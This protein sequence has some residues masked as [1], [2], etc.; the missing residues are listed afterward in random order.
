MVSK[1]NVLEIVK[2]KSPSSMV[3]SLTKSSY[4][5]SSNTLK[6]VAYNLLRNKQL[7]G[8]IQKITQTSKR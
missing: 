3:L 5:K 1:I 4:L 8:I 7:F 6:V 2:K